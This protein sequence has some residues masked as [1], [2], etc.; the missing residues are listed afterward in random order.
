MS[1]PS[2]T[3][4]PLRFEDFEDRYNYGVEFRYNAPF[5][6]IVRTLIE[7]KGASA[8]VLDIGCGE[9]IGRNRQMQRELRKVAGTYWGV[10]PDTE[11]ELEPGLFDRVEHAL[12]EDAGLPDNS[13]DVAYSFMV[14]EHVQDPDGFLKE[15]GRIL[16]PGGVFV[17]ATP[18]KHHLF[19]FLAYWTDK[20]GIADFI[21]GLI[22]KKD[23]LEH[24][25][26]LA[27]KI[28]TAGQIRARAKAAGLEAR[29]GYCETP[30]SLQNY[31]RG[32]LKLIR[33]CLIVKR[34]I[35]KQRSALCHIYGWLRKPDAG[36]S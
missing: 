32:P 25:Y 3:E 33:G 9:G 1:L 5:F 6:R 24:H 29:V 2:D 17:F 14:M 22:H 31:L 19:G 26:P 8:T 30:A 23:T 20:L 15:L 16:K 34:R 10:E 21:L 28:N 13:V 18:N 35:W 11:V 36:A 4:P 7:E 12:L 27:Y